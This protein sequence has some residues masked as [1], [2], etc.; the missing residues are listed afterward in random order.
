MFP[1]HQHC[2][3]DV[4]FL[5]VSRS[6]LYFLG[7]PLFRSLPVDSPVTCI[8]PS[9]RAAMA[10]FP[11]AQACLSDAYLSPCVIRRHSPSLW[12]DSVP[13]QASRGADV[14]HCCDI[15]L[16]AQQQ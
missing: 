2:V 12:T 11:S 9:T 13:K 16:S 1:L 8:T 3:M 6:S 10:P 7:S 5:S 4:L 14:I 15:A